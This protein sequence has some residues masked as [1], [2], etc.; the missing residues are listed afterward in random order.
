MV[1]QQHKRKGKTIVG[2]CCF[3]AEGSEELLDYSVLAIGR[4]RKVVVNGVSAMGKMVKSCFQWCFS[5]RKGKAKQLLDG[6][7]SSMRKCKEL[8]NNGV[9]AIRKNGEKQSEVKNCRTVVFWQ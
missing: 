5:N 9:S 1:F 4:R 3:I 2:R 7:V 6:V 8:L